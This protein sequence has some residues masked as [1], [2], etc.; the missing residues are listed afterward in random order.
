M[1]SDPTDTNIFPNVVASSSI[2]VFRQNVG[3]ANT[4]A[5][6][7][8]R[9]NTPIETTFDSSNQFKPLLGLYGES[10]NTHFQQGGVSNQ[11]TNFVGHF[12][13]FILSVHPLKVFQS[14]TFLYHSTWYAQ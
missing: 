12:T 11:V 2:A 7:L 8:V 4:F 14:K 6:M 9:C 3:L 13:E 5:G 1:D 10:Y